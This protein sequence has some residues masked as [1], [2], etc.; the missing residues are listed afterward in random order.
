MHLGKYNITEFDHIT[1]IFFYNRQRTGIIG[2]YYEPYIN[3]MFATENLDKLE[4]EK[5]LK[6]SL[7][8]T[9]KLKFKF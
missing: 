7:F 2:L 3:L 1:N 5:M 6:D 4:E 8:L 9:G